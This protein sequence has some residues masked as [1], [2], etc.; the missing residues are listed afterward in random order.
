[1]IKNFLT[2]LRFIK[3]M[4]TKFSLII[5]TYNE[6]ENIETLLDVLTK[7]FK[8]NKINYEIIVVDDDSPDK[9]WRIVKKFSIKNKN[10][11]LI[12]RKN[13]RGLSSAVLR[14]FEK[15][16]GDFIGVCD[17]D[18]SHDYNI[19][20]RMIKELEA[21]ELVVGSRKIK[22]GGVENWPLKRRITSFVATML[23]KIFLGV[24]LKDP[25]SGYFVF[26]RKFYN[27]VK[28]NLNAEGMS[29]KILLEM[30]VKGKPKKFKEVPF[31]FKDRT[32]GE[33]KLSGDVIKSYLKTLWRLKSEKK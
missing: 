19:L 11:K 21:Y 22:G 5:P 33:S 8:Q 12:H 14:G 28:N 24:K 31:V 15:A 3:Y 27:K 23:A 7:I 9:T 6:A 32:K 18:F 26:T 4:K 25:M 10:V 16:R 2:F 17:A 13:E 20:P 29:Y 30:Y 1:M